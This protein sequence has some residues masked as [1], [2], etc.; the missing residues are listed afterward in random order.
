MSFV[1]RLVLW[2]HIGFAIFTIGPVTVAI[3]ATPRYIR[4]RNLAVVQYLHRTTRIYTL[5]T[6][7]VL[8]A[9][10]ILGQMFHDFSKPWLSIAATLFVVALVLL[11]IILRDQ[12]KAIAALE[13]AGLR[14]SGPAGSAPAPPAAARA[15]T[16]PAT[17]NG[18]Q[19]GQPPAGGAVAAVERGRIATLGGVV[20]LI[21]LVD[22]ILMI[23]K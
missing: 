13:T 6:L 5:L 16:A 22:L 23:W 18:A 2:L 8:I 20:G 12:H 1:D 11:V 14:V 9:G 4:S 7:T 15:Q 19:P 3:A 10:L 21:W 17:G